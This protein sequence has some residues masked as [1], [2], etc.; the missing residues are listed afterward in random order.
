VN[1]REMTVFFFRIPFL[2][3]Y[4]QWKLYCLQEIVK[5]MCCNGRQKSVSEIL[6]ACSTT[7]HFL[8]TN[9]FGKDWNRSSEIQWF[10]NEDDVKIDRTEMGCE[11]VDWTHVT[12]DR[13][14]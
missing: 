2:Q 7:K 14:K 10:T 3:S 5:Q 9:K 6:G 11:N 13:D 12:Q 8:N 4:V 1:A